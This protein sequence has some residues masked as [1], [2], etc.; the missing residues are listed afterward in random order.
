MTNLSQEVSDAWTTVKAW[1][2]TRVEPGIKA[3]VTIV[4]KF[5]SNWAAQF[6]TDF[7]AKVFQIA[8]TAAESFVIGSPL[9]AVVELGAIVAKQV[10]QAAITTAEQDAQSVILNAA[11]TVLTPAT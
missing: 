1:F 10:E 9:T 7:G 4:E 2:E 6:K 3:D 8:V 5:A 11:R